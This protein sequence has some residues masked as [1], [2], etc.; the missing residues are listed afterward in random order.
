MKS[1]EIEEVLQQLLGSAV[2]PP[3]LVIT[4]RRHDEYDLLLT[5]IAALEKKCRDLD[6]QLH[7][8]SLYPVMYLQALDGLKMAR[9]LLDKL[10][11]DTSFMCSLNRRI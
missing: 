5:Q 10:N 11:I 1:D 4:L 9:K 7:R 6:Y 8:M 2:G 3:G